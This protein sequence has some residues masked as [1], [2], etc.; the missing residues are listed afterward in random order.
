MHLGQL[1][2]GR[3][4]PDLAKG[5]ITDRRRVKHRI[6]RLFGKIVQE[7]AQVRGRRKE[8]Q[9]LRVLLGPGGGLLAYQE[10]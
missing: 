1:P 2:I 4:E 9:M 7:V 5:K 8:L 10:G 3:L 6:D